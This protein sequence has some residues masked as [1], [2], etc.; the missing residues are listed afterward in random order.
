M[1]PYGSFGELTV[2]PWRQISPKAAPH[3]LLRAS[4]VR[5]IGEIVGSKGGGN[6]LE[7]EDIEGTN[8]DGCLLPSSDSKI[9]RIRWIRQ[10]EAK[11]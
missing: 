9:G 5:L 2:H 4:R 3:P 10:D 11:E 6:P 8:Q 7:K 1:R